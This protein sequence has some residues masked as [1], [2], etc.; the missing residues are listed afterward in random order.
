VIHRDATPKQAMELF[1]TLKQEK[2]A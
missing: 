1:E 2:D